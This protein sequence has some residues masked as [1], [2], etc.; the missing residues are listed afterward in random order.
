MVVAFMIGI[1]TLIQK[2]LLLSISILLGVIMR[3]CGK[4]DGNSG[5]MLSN[6]VI[7]LC[8]TSLIIYSFLDVKFSTKIIYTALFVLVLATV[9]HLMYYGIACLIYR[10]VPEKKKIILTFATIITNAGFMGIPLISELFGSEAA[11]YAT[12]YVVASNILTWTL[13]CYIYTNDKSYI[14]VKKMLWNPAAVPTY[15]G[16]LFF[17]LGGFITIPESIAP[18]WNNFL[19]PLFKDDVLFLFKSCIIPLSMVMIGVRLAESSFKTLFQDKHLP[20]YA[21]IRLLVIPIILMVILKLISL[22]GIFPQNVISDGAAVLVISA[23][24]PAGA[25]TSV[26]AERYDGDVVYAGKLVSTST[27]ISIITLPII[28]LILLQFNI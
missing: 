3:K 15:I 7:Y 1:T 28:A 8:Q 27:I 24:T 21:L 11:I 16:L 25:M 18:I 12:F 22:C 13:G 20:V 9:F 6:I 23:A 2:V 26:F 19:V 5:K 14:S 4:I 10:N 17:I